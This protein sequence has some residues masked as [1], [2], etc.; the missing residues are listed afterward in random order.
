[1]A[2]YF[3]SIIIVKGKLLLDWT[4]KLFLVAEFLTNIREMPNLNFYRDIAY[5]DRGFAVFLSP[6]RREPQS[7][8]SDHVCFLLNHFKLTERN[9]KYMLPRQWA[10]IRTDFAYDK[11]F[12][13]STG[14]II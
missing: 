13:G 12:G 5:R 11:E 14:R 8:E 6:S 4:R 10:F 7:V 1:M 9:G 3:C 2:R